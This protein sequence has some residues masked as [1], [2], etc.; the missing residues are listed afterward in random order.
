MTPTIAIDWLQ[1]HVKVP[2]SNYDRCTINKRYRIT[3]MEYQTRHFRGVYEIF[4]IKANERVATLA[5]E[6]HSHIMSFDSGLLKLDNK[7]LYQRDLYTFAQTL[8]KDLRLEFRS[9]SRI[10][11]AVDFLKFDN[12]FCP[13]DLIQG[14]VS[15]MYIKKGRGTKGRLTFETKNRSKGEQKKSFRHLNFQTLKFGSEVSDT[16]YYLYNKTQELQQVVMKPYIQ[17]NWSANGWDGIQD[18]WRLEFS[19]KSN[20]D[21]IVEVDGGYQLQDF[22]DINTIK[23]IEQIFN[24]QFTKLFSFVMNEDKSRVDRMTPLVL[25]ENLKC[26]AVK[27]SLSTKKDGSRSSK[28]FAKGLLMLTNQEL[29]GHDFD[30]AIFSNSLLGYYIVNRGITE[31]AEKKLNYKV[32]DE[33]AKRN[34]SE[35]LAPML[36]NLMFNSQLSQAAKKRLAQKY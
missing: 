9:I 1:F 2:I 13:K 6:P 23:N 33:I 31:W 27:I 24:Y 17:D 19:M 32:P 36:C 11:I 10:D 21:T 34:Q 30:L 28:I 22:K 16:T 12:D 5:C 35:L 3:K 8:L 18:V 7:Y 25:F 26:N 15:D 14:Y 20:N 4:D 29:R